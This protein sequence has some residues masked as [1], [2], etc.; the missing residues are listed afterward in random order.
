M[1]QCGTP[2]EE[3]MDSNNQ[4]HIVRFVNT[5]SPSY[6]IAVKQ[7]LLMECRNIRSALFLMLV[8]Y[9]VFNIEYCTKV[10]DVL[11]RKGFMFH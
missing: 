2:A 11:S 7:N 9:Y 3:V 5:S 10:K 8:T 4:P 6:F 1:F